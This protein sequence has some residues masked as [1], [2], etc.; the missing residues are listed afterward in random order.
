[1]HKS[2]SAS[3]KIKKIRKWSE[4]STFKVPVVMPQS[5]K[6]VFISPIGAVSVLKIL[7]NSYRNVIILKEKSFKPFYF[8][9]CIMVKCANF[10][11]P[12]AF[13][14]LLKFLVLFKNF[15][16]ILQNTGHLQWALLKMV[17]AIFALACNAKS[18][19]IT[20]LVFF[21]CFFWAVI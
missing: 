19:A 1:M 21:S 3:F 9:I 15:W 16:S 12:T 8:S 20:F 4:T 11:L 13:V 10:K 18:F 5:K 7:V 17:F 2:I 14:H 6:F